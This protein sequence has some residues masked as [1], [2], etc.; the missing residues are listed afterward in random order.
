M[1]TI[2]QLGILS[3]NPEKLCIT[4]PNAQVFFLQM[5]LLHQSQEGVERHGRTFHCP[6]SRSDGPGGHSK[7]MLLQYLEPVKP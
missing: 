3:T 2:H 1:I 6:G 4:T 5:P 7:G